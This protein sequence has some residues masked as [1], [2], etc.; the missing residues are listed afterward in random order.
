MKKRH[1]SSRLAE[2]VVEIISR[3]TPQEKQELSRLLNWDELESLR[4]ADSQSNGHPD[5]PKLYLGTT[6]RG[7]SLEIPSEKVSSVFGVLLDE[8]APKRIEVFLLG[9]EDFGELSLSEDEF[10]DLLQREPHYF[11]ERYATLEFGDHEIVC[12]GD[13]C[14]S[15]VLSS[16]FLPGRKK[17]AGNLLKA[18]GFPHHFKKDEFHAIVWENELEVE[19]Q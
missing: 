9:P 19:E 8:L 11:G 18:C 3:M 2:A 10:R 17:L 4:E 14:L 12:G 1:S 5:E 16:S 6:P 7:L 15:I 13:G